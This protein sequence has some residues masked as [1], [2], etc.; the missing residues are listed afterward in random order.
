MQM[1]RTIITAVAL[2]VLAVP[3]AAIASH[4]G[5][6]RH[7]SAHHK[8]HHHQAHIVRFGAVTSSA[9]VSGTSA[10]SP[11]TTTVPTGETAGTIASFTNGTLTITL[12]DG[13]MVSGKVTEVTEIECR[14]A[15]ASAASDGHG[16]NGDNGQD[17]QGDG[18]GDEASSGAGQGDD[19]QGDVSGRDA[20][21]QQ[22]QA[23]SCTSAALVQ[24]AVVREAELRVSSTGA[25]WE[26]VELNQ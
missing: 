25:T 21:D 19:Q 10:P 26:K 7:E 20:D 13:S 6:S 12:N 22:Q 1:R 14:S 9:P 5:H 23:Q 11:A 18:H 17:G 2:T 4:E 8:R 3:G 15:M 24:G 16:D